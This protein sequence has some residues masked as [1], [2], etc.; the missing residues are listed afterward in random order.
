VIANDEAEAGFFKKNMN[1]VEFQR[2]KQF[3]SGNALISQG[4]LADLFKKLAFMQA[5]KKQAKR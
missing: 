5:R 4:L 2:M 3:S 1:L